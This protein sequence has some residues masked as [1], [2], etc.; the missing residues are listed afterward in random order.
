MRACMRACVCVRAHVFPP[1]AIVSPCART[2]A[3]CYYLTVCTYLRRF[4]NILIIMCSSPDGLY[5]YSSRLPV[6]NRYWRWTVILKQYSGP[7]KVYAVVFY[8]LVIVVLLMWF[9]CCLYTVYLV[10]IRYAIPVYFLFLPGF[11]SSQAFVFP[12]WDHGLNCS[13]QLLW[14]KSID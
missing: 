8:L 7:V 3:D 2:S 14:E 10:Y 4:A 6:G 1:V 5:L 9:L 12:L 13:Y 11:L